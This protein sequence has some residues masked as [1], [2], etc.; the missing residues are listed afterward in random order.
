MALLTIFSFIFV[1]AYPPGLIG[2]FLMLCVVLYGW[3]A[4][5]FYVYVLLGKQKMTKKQKDWLQ[6][7][8]IAAAVLSI[9]FIINSIYIYYDPKALDQAIASMPVQQTD[10]KQLIINTITGF[11]IVFVLLLTHII[12]TYILVRKNKEY[13]V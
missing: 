1:M 7:N 6:V 3:F 12:W 10:T 2:T 13:F 4:N 9:L 8:A 5:R 11:L